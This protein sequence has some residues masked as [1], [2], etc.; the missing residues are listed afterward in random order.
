MAKGRKV[1][2]GRIFSQGTVKD[3]NK[4]RL[5][6]AKKWTL[7]Q[8]KYVLWSDESKFEMFSSKRYVFVRRRVCERIISTC[9]VPTLKDGGG[10][11]MMWGGFAGD[12]VCDLFRIQGTLNQHVY[13]SFLQ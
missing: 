5:A 6:W 2:G 8:C 9:V 4:K 7:D 10:G 12:T 3:T 11:V 1:Q 13:N